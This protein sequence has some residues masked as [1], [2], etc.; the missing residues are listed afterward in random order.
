MLPGDAAGPEPITNQLLGEEAAPRP[1]G[2]LMEELKRSCWDPLVE[3]RTG[4]PELPRGGGEEGGRETIYCS[5]P[6]RGG[7]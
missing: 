1:S 4:N 6:R 7:S 2:P 5:G 3:G